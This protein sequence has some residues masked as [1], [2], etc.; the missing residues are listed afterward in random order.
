MS[1]QVTTQG[2]QTWTGTSLNLAQ[3]RIQSTTNI[4]F[5]GLQSAA[6]T[7]GAKIWAQNVEMR[8]AGLIN[9]AGLI[10]AEKD[11]VFSFGQGGLTNTNSGTDSGLIAKNGTLTIT[12]GAVTNDGGYMGSGSTF[13]AAVSSWDNGAGTVASLG[14]L[15][16][17]SVGAVYNAG[18]ISAQNSLQLTGTNLTQAASGRLLGGNTLRVALT[19][20]LVNAGFID[21]TSTWILAAAIT[22]TGSGTI[23]GDSIFLNAGILV[24][25]SSA[26]IS[27][28]DTLNI[29]AGAV[30]NQGAILSGGNMILGGSMDALGLVQGQAGQVANSGRMQAGGALGLAVA[31][32]LDNSGSIY[33]LGDVA[34]TAG[35]V[36]SSGLLASQ[37]TL[38]IS[39]S[40]LSQGAG[41]TLGSGVDQ[42]GNLITPAVGTSPD[43]LVFVQGGYNSQGAVLS[44]GKLSVQAGSSITQTGSVSTLGD[45][46]W[47]GASL[48]FSGARVQG[49]GSLLLQDQGVFTT[50][51]ATIMAKSVT[52]S[53]AGLMNDASLIQAENDLTLSLGGGSLVNANSG[54]SHGLI[55]KSGNL[56]IT[57]GGVTNNGGYMAAGNT[58][59]AKVSSWDNGTGTATSLGNLS[60]NSSGSINNAGSMTAS[61]G[62]ALSGTYLGLT[63]D[64]SLTAGGT[65]RADISG[66]IDNRGLIDADFTWLTAQT[67][68]NIGTGVIYGDRIALGAGTL[69]N[70]IENAGAAIASRGQLDIGAGT[71]NN[72][73]VYDA[74]NH[75]A[76]TGLILS[77]GDMAIGGGLDSSGRATGM[78]G[79]LINNGATIE[80][81]GNMSIAMGGIQNLNIHLAVTQVTRAPVPASTGPFETPFG[82]SFFTGTETDTEDVASEYNPGI[83]R[84][85]G[86][87]SINAGSILN[88]DSQ[89]LAGGDL[90]IQG[91]AIDNQATQGNRTAH[92]VGIITYGAGALVNQVPW[93]YDEST[94]IALTFQGY[95]VALSQGGL[96]MVS[97]G[98][99]GQAGTGGMGNMQGMG[100]TG[101]ASMPFWMYGPGSI[102]PQNSL[103]HI[104]KDPGASVLI[105]T[106][107]RFTR[108]RGYLSSDYLLSKLNGAPTT[109]KR[110]GDGFYE[111]S[112]VR[113]QISQTTGKRF[114]DGYRNDEEQYRALLDA[115]A[116]FGNAHNLQAGVALSSEM[117]AQLSQDIVWLVAEEVPLPD[118]TT[119]TALV[120]KFYSSLSQDDLAKAGGLIA[121]DKNLAVA[122][123]DIV[124]S[125]TIAGRD[126][127]SLNANTI[128]NT[129]TLTGGVV[130]AR[131]Q[132]DF[133]QVGGSIKAAQGI[134]LDVGRDLVM[135]STV[136]GMNVV[137][138][139]GSVSVGNN[140]DR[141]SSMSVTG[142]GGIIDIAAG[143]KIG[144]SGAQIINGLTPGGDLGGTGLTSLTAGSIDLGTVGLSSA[145]IVTTGKGFSMSA[146][147]TEYGSSIIGSG[148]VR[149]IAT[150][151]DITLRDSAVASGSDTL[152]AA[153][154]GSIYLTP[155][156]SVSGATGKSSSSSSSGFTSSTRSL[157]IQNVQVDSLGSVVTSQGDV[158]AVAKDTIEVNGSQIFGQNSTF[159][160]ADHIRNVASTDIAA[161]L[162]VMKSSSTGVTASVG[163]VTFGTT[164]SQLTHDGVYAGSTPSVIGAPSSDVT[165]IAHDDYLQQGSN[166]LA[167]TL[168]LKAKKAS[169]LAQPTP[170]TEG[171][172]FK[173]SQAGLTLQ[174]S[175]PIV[176]EGL[177]MWNTAQNMGQTS[178]SS[179]LAAGGLTLGLAG[180]NAYDDYVRAGKGMTVPTLGGGD[181]KSP[182]SGTGLGNAVDSANSL[183][184]SAGGLDISI[185]FGAS[186]SQSS[187]VK[188]GMGQTGSNVLANTIVLNIGDPDNPN[189]QALTI[190][191]SDVLASGDLFA[192]VIG[193]TFI[194][195]SQSIQTM[196]G[197]NSS[198]GYSTGVGISMGND[199]MTVY[200]S[201]S[202]NTSQGKSSGDS[203]SNTYSHF[204]GTNLTSFDI[205]GD[206]TM[207]GGIILGDRIEGNIDGNLTISSPQDRSTYNSTQTGMSAGAWIGWNLNTWSPR[208][209]V[210]ASVT[211]GN[212][213]ANYRSV[214]EEQAG[215]TAGDGGFNITVGGTTSLTGAVIS[216]S[217]KAVDKGLNY[218]S[219]NGLL[220]NDLE[221]ESYYNVNS[222]SLGMGYS[223]GSGNGFSGG[224]P[225]VLNSSSSDW[226]TT[227]SGISGGTIIN[228]GQK[229]AFDSAG[230]PINTDVR[231]GD[232]SGKV[233]N[234]FNLD[235]IKS[236][237]AIGRALSQE[238][239]TFLSNRAQE[240]DAAQKAYNEEWY[241]GAQADP[242]KLAQLG[243]A[244]DDA[245]QWGPGG[246][247]RLVFTAI[248]GGL[249][250]N[251]GGSASQAMQSAVVTAVQGLGTNAVKGLVDNYEK[252]A[253]SARGETLRTALQAIVGCAGAAASG[254]N[255]GSGALGASASVVLNDLADL[256]ASTNAS[257]LTAQ[258]KEARMNLVTSLVGGVTAALGG[259]TAAAV[260]AARVEQENNYAALL[261]L[262]P[263]I[264]AE[265]PAIAQRLQQIAPGLAQLI[266]SVNANDGSGSASNAGGNNLFENPP[267][268]QG[269]GSPNDPEKQNNKD[270]ADKIAN[271]H[272]FQKHVLDNNE[273]GGS[274]TTKKQFAD[275]IESVMN[276]PTHTGKL[277][278]GRSYFYDQQTN[279]VVISNPSA[280]D[281]G[282][283]FQINKFLY[284]NPL[285]YLKTLR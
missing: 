56:A 110:L 144:L 220:L 225:I 253:G 135:R 219:T 132:G 107:S 248:T 199:G 274:I 189:A 157:A 160:E 54:S 176:N 247:Y 121:S 259:D 270:T 17:A 66:T 216:S 279:T 30:T 214:G 182:L 95:P 141:V 33:A 155:G 62:M 47:S 154:Q 101:S 96:N 131:T 184:G 206:L 137:V 213:K 127:L 71:L 7:S 38:A 34:V 26:T 58:F 190:V 268:G 103:Y 15:S 18:T 200:A 257:N 238:A 222:M 126:T 218:L 2:D 23:S 221:N 163:G 254:G 164:N 88:K 277:Q 173:T 61:G 246:T 25:G 78:G 156:Q 91:A 44:A 242:E 207:K 146:S 65:L 89:I 147:S 106:D 39:A 68:N 129:G 231:T 98:A 177:T 42:H 151:G 63:R 55:A 262:W 282:T 97:G 272:A 57:A 140:I 130:A 266:F 77:L 31:Q 29:G 6:I 22:N 28:T 158:I 280:V 82:W 252:V 217:Q 115:G 235:E 269:G 16:L 150:G 228:N 75:T 170:F 210:N 12:A 13:S 118:G 196:V 179:A 32:G 255:C 185:K 175:N 49:G 245:K 114:L 161:D 261:T 174:V 142:T 14:D 168:Y 202:A 85:G 21:P 209:G 224:L 117:Q 236:Q 64:A 81:M 86:S 208:G 205:S 260:L 40:S 52:L 41:G 93:A 232:D 153:L 19:Q 192:K 215:I 119:T 10:Q 285:D 194:G 223:P 188:V 256:A 258:E 24:N 283:A 133:T 90:S 149:L 204:G 102:L 278:N 212:A 186:Q 100:A 169:I 84:S 105:E 72:Q 120:P 193:N 251:L 79:S 69:N 43:L 138:L 191:G 59:T 20:D 139:G 233:E 80:S 263:E 243:K 73:G 171:T 74:G 83:I 116:S 178:S 227:V 234:T 166:L 122:G 145:A 265:L 240:L 1:G 201:A 87:M 203:L 249:T 92:Y 4:L 94:T 165:I 143:G 111:Q 195:T 123:T 48:N 180:K 11:L 3:S 136:S 181:S 273:F 187:Q 108:N 112:L 172:V 37:G 99:P 36:S 241:K 167:D 198:S 284:S 76:T 281:G 5:Q 229:V 109:G 197:K 162:T 35:G 53:A 148:S 125:G 67:L 264:G 113:N 152:L 46:T 45:Q 237:L 60:I 124:N 239:G 250:G 70:A 128:Q 8:T 276:N 275:R 27:A 267:T 104:N 226:G 244:A 9:N 230:R 50:N 271:G 134:L 159:L 51:G 183:A 211:L